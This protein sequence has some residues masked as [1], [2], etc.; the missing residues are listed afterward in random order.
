MREVA[1]MRHPPPSNY[2]R[3]SVERIVGRRKS[4][5]R[6]AP[7]P[8]GSGTFDLGKRLRDLRV[9]RRLSLEEIA[10]KTGLTKGFLSLVERGLKAPSISSLLR[11]SHAYGMS[12]GALLDGTPPSE[13]AYSL[14]RRDQRRKYAREG[15]LYGYR[16]EAIAFRKER[17]R[18]EPFI[19]SPPVRTPRK[20]FTHEGDEMVFVLEGQ[21]ELQLDSEY[22]LLS[23][24][25]CIYFDAKLPHRSRSIG[26]ERATT[27]V[28]VS[29]S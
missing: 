14:V 4:K 19:V 27:L 5:V 28:T 6:A 26:P 16:Y 17:K 10:G 12:V 22:I 2:R 13:P 20:F 9:A 7:A 25:D 23:S 15:S 29:E 3:R 8:G 1:A 18:M 24:G 21:V 11:L